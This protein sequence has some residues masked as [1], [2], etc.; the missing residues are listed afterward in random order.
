MKSITKIKKQ[1]KKKTNEDI[2]KT[3]LN[4]AKNKKWL[5]VARII[6][7]PRRKRKSVNLQEINKEY[8]DGDIIVVPGKVLS[9]GE[10]DKKIKIVALG[11][12][13]SAKEKLSKSKKDFT[14]LIDE[15]K[16]NPDAKGVKIFANT[17]Q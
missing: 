4:A 6:S 10:I 2:V 7:S 8:K 12:S 14:Y 3:I 16:K 17:K 1:I 11:F 15:I 9:Q 13:E 5:D